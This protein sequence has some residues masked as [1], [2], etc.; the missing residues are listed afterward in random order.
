MEEGKGKLGVRPS[1]PPNTAPAQHV[2]EPGSG[3]RG[4]GEEHN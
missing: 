3:H 1:A 2:A 4:E